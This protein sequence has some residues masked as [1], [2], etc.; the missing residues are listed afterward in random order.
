M[1]LCLVAGLPSAVSAQPPEATPP[2]REIFVPFEDLNVLLEGDARRVFLTRDEYR[3]LVAKARKSPRDH[4]PQ[5]VLLLAAEYDT[6][7]QPG[8]ATTRGQLW[9]EVLEA[10]V[11]AVPLDLQ[12][13]GIRGALLDNQPAALGRNEQGRVVLFV[14]GTGRQQLTLE[15]V[16]PLQTSAAQQSLQFTLPTPA[17]TRHRLTAPGN[18]EVRG[19]AAVVAREVD[20]AANVTRLEILARPGST[21]LVMSLNN[22]LLLQQRVLMA[23]SVIV[24]EVTQAYER[25]HASF[26]MEVLH[27]AVE[28]LRFRVPAGFEVTDVVSPLLSRWIVSEA[29]AQQVLELSLREPTTGTVAINIAAVKN[30]ADLAGWRM[31]HLEPLDVTS[32]VSVLG[33]LVE[34]RLAA[35]SLTSE[36]VIA[37]DSAVLRQAL[38]DSLFETDP[39]APQLRPVA[40]FFAPEGQYELTARFRRPPASLKVQTAMLLTLRDRE[41]H[42]RGT[43]TLM[44]EMEKQFA[45]DI[46]EPAGWR[47]S[48]ITDQGGATV[49]F[50]R[51]QSGEGPGQRLNVR[52]PAG[53][54][55]GATS[56]L[57]FEAT[58][59]PPGW[60]DAWTDMTATFPIFA[61]TDAAENLGAIA[62]QTQDDL[63]AR[64]DQLTGLTPLAA[65]E[66]AALGLPEA[67][68][69]LAFRINDSNYA[70]SFAVQRSAPRITARAMSFLKIEPDGLS[71]HYEI[72]YDIQQARARRLAF[73]LP[74]NTPASILIQGLEGLQ[75]KEYSSQIAD[76]R[77][78]WNVDLSDGVLGP[79]RLSV[80]FEQTLPGEALQG[81]VL[82][83]A[84]AVDVAYQTFVVAVEGSPEFDIQ[85]RTTG[86]PLDVG[87]L[88]DANHP[89]GRRLLGAYGFLSDPQVTLDIEPRPGYGLPAAI[90]ERAELVTLLSS[91]GESQTAARY[92]LR[93][94]A[95]F[96][97]IT[98]PSTDAKLWSATVDGK[99]ATPQRDVDD[100]VISLPPAGEGTLRDLQIV[101]EMPVQPILFVRDIEA[102]A[103]RLA[104][105]TESGDERYEVP[106][107]DVH[108][109]LVL[110]EGHRVLRTG[111]TVFT[112]DLTSRTKPAFVLGKLLYSL[113]GGITPFGWLPLATAPRV[114]RWDDEVHRAKSLAA[115]SAATA[116]DQDSRQWGAYF[117]AQPASPMTAPVPSTLDSPAEQ[118]MDESK[119][120]DGTQ[121]SDPFAA[122]QA[123]PPPTAQPEAAGRAPAGP[124]PAGGRSYWALEGVRSLQ[125]AL[126]QSGEQVSFQ[127]LG[128]A[129]RLQATLMQTSRL[130]FLSWGLALLVGLSGFWRTNSGLRQKA[131][132]VI[133]MLVTALVTPLLL[134]LLFDL[135]LSWVFEP[136]FFVAAGLVPYYLAVGLAQWLAAKFPRRWL[137]GAAATATAAVVVWLT[138]WSPPVQAQESARLSAPRG[139]LDAEELMLLLQPGKPVVLP[140]DAVIIPYDDTAPGGMQAAEKVLVPYDEYARLWNLA[141]PE[142]PLD[143]P[144][145]PAPFAWAGARYSATLEGDE[146]VQVMGRIDLEVFHAGPLEIPLPLQDGVLER[147]TLDGRAARLRIIASQPDVAN[148]G[149]QQAHPPPP[150]GALALL[151]VSEP[152]RKQLELAARFRLERSGGWRILHGR[153]P[154]APATALQLRVPQARTEVRLA[155]VL[156]RTAYET[157]QNDEAIETALPQDGSLNLQW[158]PQVAAAQVDQSLT[159]RSLGLLDVRE[160]G[161]RLAWQ[162]E[163]QSPASQRETF[164]LLVP[165]EYLVDG[166]RGDNVRGWRA[167]ENGDAQQIDIT[168]LKPATGAETITLQLSLRQVIGAMSVTQLTAPAVVVPD[169]VLHQGH[170]AIRRGGLLDV[171]VEGTRD[172]TRAEI[173]PELLAPVLSTVTEESPLPLKPFQN[174]RFTRADFGL[175]LSARQYT[176][177][178]SVEEHA[179]LRIA[180]RATTLETRFQFDIRDRA[181]HEL[182]LYIPANLAIKEVFVPGAF[183]WA[184]TDREGRRLLTVYLSEG[185]MGRVDL[186]LRGTLPP[187]TAGTVAAPRFELLDVE[188]QAGF[189]V[190]QVDP[191]VSVV[192][193]EL[194]NAEEVPL[195]R[196]WG[197]VTDQQRQLARL[198]VF[199]RAADYSAT[200]RVT[201]RQP[202]VNGLSVT[203][204]RVTPRD[205]EE[206]IF[207][208]FQIRD[209]GIRELSFLLPAALQ[210]ARVTVPLLRQKTVEPLANNPGTVR[211]RIELQDEVIDQLIVLVQGSRA[212]TPTAYEVPVPTLETGTTDDRYAVL[213]SAG[214]DEV[215]VAA[216]VGFTELN[217]QL[218][219]WKKLAEILG[220]HITQAYVAQSNVAAPRLAIQTRERATVATAGARIGLAQTLLIVDGHGAY[221]GVQEYRLDNKTEQFLE[222]ELPTDAELWT[223]LVAGQTVKPSTAPNATS[224][225]VRVPL[226]KTQTGDL[227]YPVVLKY[228]GHLDRLGTLR[229]VNFPLMRTVNINVEQS[230][231]R[232]R[233][234][235]THRWLDFGGR[236]SQ[237]TDEDELTADFVSYQTK[238]M[239]ELMQVL[240]SDSYD[241]FS[242]VRA[243]ISVKS[244][245]RQLGLAI[246]DYQNRSRATGNWR[247][248]NEITSNTAVLQEAQRQLQEKSA[249]A[250][251]QEFDN[252]ERL[253]S[254]YDS[255]IS[256]RSKNVVNE[257]GNNFDYGVQSPATGVSRID[258]FN[259][260]WFRSNSLGKDVSQLP[261]AEGRIAEAGQRPGGEGPA[262][263]DLERRFGE[264]REKGK[265]DLDGKA[266]SPPGGS[267]SDLG[268]QLYRYQQQLEQQSVSPNQAQLEAVTD[269]LSAPRLERSREQRDQAGEATRGGFGGAGFG[270]GAA[271]GLELAGATTTPA[272]AP[273]SGLASLDVVFPE[274]G[275]EYF[276]TT[277]RGDIEITARAM[278]K[279]QLSR[280]ISLL[281]IAAAVAGAIMLFR[282]VRACCLKMN[283]RLLAALLLGL[284]LVSVV[285]F[286]FPVLGLLAILAGVGVLLDRRAA[287]QAA[288]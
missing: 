138:V 283:K 185:V 156:D 148:S 170:L 224:Q 178:V 76:G 144:A 53:V 16:M 12:G 14:E 200:F 261:A 73:S 31:P 43:L 244:N 20:E 188:K 189:V 134:G 22:R 42:V 276:F 191:S 250:V 2:I 108:W 61:V 287:A 194:S 65:S 266:E 114:A 15:L 288:A 222:I 97:Q 63:R 219:P 143:E 96:L 173:P 182:Q 239:Q 240:K 121:V 179:L 105:R 50:E 281:V 77:R 227:D 39:G 153:L 186:D 46:L 117:G 68:G 213:E 56:T 52:L 181:R 82:P 234:P 273:A 252:V 33:V 29:E 57:T 116:E 60:L 142:R 51:M 90:T 192:A 8:R 118:P 139:A 278:P 21:A 190:V 218:S 98:L 151:Y 204:V 129:P 111:G 256:N 3:E 35:D 4:A 44:P 166:V 75:V 89:V 30:A 102:A 264:I 175:E 270:G 92:L 147:A 279:S 196:V 130:Q 217:R 221:R 210:D 85:V 214:R 208:Q 233:L 128:V 269:A 7:V 32:H 160:D 126:E 152:G 161:V 236:M 177:R 168:L 231:V 34:D 83:L 165:R 180:E 228:G 13:V 106:T 127:S 9:L 78:R 230:H 237:V 122:P 202:Q 262:I 100:L 243:E 86:R 280:L 104:V 211:F 275:T 124:V 81:Y 253:Q 23:R 48:S 150:P 201:P 109:Q 113:T 133:A 74:E 198:A 197:W 36:K 174:Y 216:N 93:T 135:E 246:Q 146:Y 193:E 163:L 203:N 62:V 40:A 257:L 184:E 164:T 1:L 255:Q 238:Q 54:A 157:V 247:L 37:I 207:L 58:S 132:Y 25:L 263:E 41:Q 249:G 268:Q 162:L 88:A 251:S 112:D 24:S 187:A 110:P 80:D 155:N 149:M 55:P 140:K 123:A 284:G 229:T 226:I 70:A 154:A 101:F 125:I 66:Q 6:Q 141:F 64:P 11:Q 69:I 115:T 167:R 212:L 10:G 72:I 241:K 286:I 274:R 145:A 260:A 171:R 107:A 19:G 259:G 79:A 183:S 158:R 267:R 87:E 282:L 137:R 45:V 199:H 245:L 225:R 91:S 209:A 232:L 272:Q 131:R 38:P 94:K 59:V 195:S 27:G 248:Q 265:P 136:M 254:L 18:V 67:E 242:K 5:A 235:E 205:I 47:V 17:A 84:Q 119:P 258:N 103:P 277:P 220:G 28:Q 26:S 172:L 120:A 285:T 159:A 215:V 95:A 223:V 71:A 49:P 206:T 169:A 176:S 99:P 271:A